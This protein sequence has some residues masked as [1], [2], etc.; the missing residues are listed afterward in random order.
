MIDAWSIYNS[1]KS[2]VMFIVEDVTYNVCDQKFHEFEIRKLN[3]EVYVIRKTLTEVANEGHLG[4]GKR[5][6]IGSQEV[7]VVYFRCGY[8]PDQY[9]TQREWDAR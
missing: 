6:F 4:E 8:H 1:K 7:A 3:P 9:P 5:L 2:V